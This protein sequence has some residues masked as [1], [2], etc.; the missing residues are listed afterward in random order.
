MEEIKKKMKK[1]RVK[2]RM[3]K[4]T[5]TKY[6]HITQQQNDFFRKTCSPVEPIWVHG[7]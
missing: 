6:T 5:I 1:G 3:K 4:V 7:W 2:K